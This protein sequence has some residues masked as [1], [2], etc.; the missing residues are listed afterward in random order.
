MSRIY[1]KFIEYLELHLIWD[2]VENIANEMC[3]I[4]QLQS[5]NF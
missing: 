3:T 5:A 4:A 1:T 2:N